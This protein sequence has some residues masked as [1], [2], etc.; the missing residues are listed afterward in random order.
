V[1][2]D[3]RGGHNQRSINKHFFKK[4][5]A[6][7]AYV[8]GFIFAD[9]AVEDVRKSSRTC[10]TL[11]SN[12]HKEILIDIK[13]SLHS[14]HQLRLRKPR[15]QVFPGGGRYFC[16][17]SYHLRIGSK[18]IFDD[19][20][21]L[22]VTPR[23]SL[24][25]KFPKVPEPYLNHFIRGYF[26]G[27]GCVHVD[28]H[29]GKFK[30]RLS[31]IFTCGS[32]QFLEKLTKHLHKRAKLSFQNVFFQHRAFRLRFGTH[33]SLKLLNF[34]YKGINKVPYLHYKHDIYKRYLKSL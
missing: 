30:H 8:T 25:L 12:N 4:W 24:T 33:D 13:R 32:R 27:D 3:P 31:T 18:E 17:A 15:W 21:R 14:N 11:I 2:T 1:Y 26:D 7:M 16:K 19:L 10:Y 28:T 23:K 20:N 9:G 5:S 29:Q 34:I 22:G 6:N